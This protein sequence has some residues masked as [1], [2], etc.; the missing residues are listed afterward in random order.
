MK[1]ELHSL[2]WKNTS[3]IQE[4]HKKVME[5]FEIPVNYHC[6]DGADHGTFCD[7]IMN[8]CQ[9]E[10]CGIIDIDCIPT[11]KEAIP[12]MIDWVVKNG[13]FIGLA[14]TANHIQPRTHISAVVTCSFISK[15]FY[16]QIG[17]PSFKPNY[18][19]DVS[20]ELSYRADELGITYRA[21]YPRRYEKDATEGRWRLNNYGYFGIG[22]YYDIGIYHL[23]QSRMR[24]NVE[25]FHKRCNEVING[26]FNPN[27][28]Q[29]S[30]TEL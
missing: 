16:N 18:R 20:E 5:H 8:D 14:Q 24:E 22:T 27:E 28:L 11:N 2:Y 23:Y 21:I 3:E 30:C 4:S 26:T 13:S 7:H 29:F 19:S 1:V 12:K 17:R 15:N 25:L 10:I 9:S 6:V